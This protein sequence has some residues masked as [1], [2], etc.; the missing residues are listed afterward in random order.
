MRSLAQKNL[1]DRVKWGQNFRLWQETF[2]WYAW[3]GQKITRIFLPSISSKC[4]LTFLSHLSQH[5][6]THNS[7][8]CAHTI[9]KYIWEMFVI[10]RNLFPSIGTNVRTMNNFNYK[11]IGA[12]RQ[13]CSTGGFAAT[14]LIGR[15]PPRHEGYPCYM[16]LCD[17][18]VV[19]WRHGNPIHYKYFS[20]KKFQFTL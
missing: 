16:H 20:Y 10:A 6:G 9:D 8:V 3:G 18:T 11:Q 1:A 5:I 2:K 17:Q 13:A 12:G 14:K 15:L 4:S 7:T 19:P